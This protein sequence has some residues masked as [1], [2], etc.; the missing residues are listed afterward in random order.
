M[1]K[2]GK[3]KKE[4]LIASIPDSEKPFVLPDGWAWCRLGQVIHDL[5]RNGYSSK[6][7][8]YKTAVKSLKLGAR[9]YG[10]FNPNEY[11]YVAEEISEDSIF[12]LEPEDN[13]FS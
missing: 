7:V 4:K 1:I 12:W 3:I 5:P 2:N 11:K 9:I 10:I 8:S 6:E 13:L